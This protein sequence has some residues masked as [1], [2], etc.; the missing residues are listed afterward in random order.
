MRLRRFLTEHRW[1]D[2]AMLACFILAFSGATYNHVMDIVRGGLF[3]YSRW[4]GA[5]MGL[6][7]YWTSLSVLDPLA[8]AALIWRVRLGY[9]VA[10]AIMLTN[11]PINIYAGAVYWQLPVSENPALIMQT[12]FLVFLLLTVHRVWR[13]SRIN[14]D[15]FQRRIG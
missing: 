13:L 11:V 3:P 14:D 8:I 4:C 9:V 15:Q 2:S 7:I 1:Y 12:A 10:L 5:P 6:N